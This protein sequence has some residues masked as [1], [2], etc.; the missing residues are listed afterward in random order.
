M[1]IS[2][3]KIEEI[4]NSVDIVDVISQH[5]QLRKRGKNFIGLCPFHSEKTPSFT[6][7]EDKQ[8]FHCFGC[9]TG[10]NVFKFLTEFHKISFVEAVQEIADQQGITI[11]FD[12]AEYIEQQSEQE[13]LYDINTEAAR[14]FLNNLLNDDEGEFA[15]KYLQERNIKTQTLRSF[16]LGYSLKGWENFINY[17]KSRNLN[18]D[19][20][21]QLGLIGKNSE[22]KLY[23]KLPGRLIFPIFS[24]NGRV[25][26][27]AGRV[28]PSKAGSDDDANETGAKYI[29]SPESLIYIKGRILYGLSFAK[30][31]IRRLDKAI[32][33]E[34]Y[35]DLISLYQS[36]IK[37]VVAVSGT[38]LTDD[39]V[40]LLSRYTK[41]V[42]LLFDAD[43][44]GIKASMRSIEILL[45]R[46]MEVK[47]VS[48]P[49]GEDPDSFVNKFGNVEFE[50][51]VKK[52]ENFL[53]YETKYYESLG[54]FEDPSTAAE[55]IRELVKPVALIDDE[56]KR[57]L[58][59]R[60][61]AQKFNLREKLIESEL[62]KQLQQANKAERR[63]KEEGRRKMENAGEEIALILADKTETTESPLLYSLEKEI[64]K[65]LFEAEKTIAELIF[66]Y[67]HPED[68]NNEI[69]RELFEIV[70]DVFESADGGDN[71]TTSG[72]VGILKDEKKE[73]YIRELT[74]DK[75]SIS[76]NWEER[77]P[78]ITA[79]MTLMK[80]AK[81][82]V[83]KFV[84]ERIE[85]RIKSN[86]RE[87][88]LTEDESKLLELMKN[89]NELERE[90][91]RI[92]EELSDNKSF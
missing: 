86:R 40:Q 80:Y 48:L 19:K 45:K 21:I 44:A 63:K 66:T 85:K 29:N 50:E 31:D 13:V 55:A 34:G 20:C 69:N 65:L 64:L 9:H 60:N 75:Y 28:L 58:L 7:S 43:V 11:E 54:K 5:V 6:V 16:G 26:A 59:I 2:E 57:N 74:F 53:E 39:Q 78:S 23:D 67:L 42:V 70:K 49:K 17:A 36:G 25:V 8:I 12:K 14:Y 90:K 52:A 32:I 62:D 68:F 18:I 73:I 89:N 92:R 72:L 87:I 47:I 88:E 4:R 35:M 61:I 71:F 24:P 30:D 46:D 1:R 76:S 77:F 3:S 83:M 10:G 84:I 37:N 22:G 51:L 91:K 56:L 33:V 81:D 79:E 27:F 38:A 15:R 41:N 82:S